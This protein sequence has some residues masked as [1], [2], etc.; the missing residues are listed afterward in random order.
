[1]VPGTTHFW[2]VDDG[3]LLLYRAVFDKL[4]RTYPG[5]FK[6]YFRTSVHL[7]D[8]QMRHFGMKLIE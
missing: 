1:M 8:M 5:S 2:T 4:T 7:V 6:I 3:A